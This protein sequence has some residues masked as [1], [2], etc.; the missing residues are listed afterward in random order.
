MSF[1]QQV[2]I[3]PA[4]AVEGDFASSNPRATVLAGGGA[5]VAGTGGLI[6]GRFAWVTLDSDGNPATALN[7][8]QGVPDG[9]VHREQQ[10]ILTQYLQEY[11]MLIP[12][13][14]MV[15]LH[16][17]GDFWMK[18]RT[19]ATRKQKAFASYIDGGLSTAAAGGSVAGFSGTASFATNVM[20]V[21]AVTSGTVNKGTKVTGAGVPANTYVTG[22]LTGTPGGAGT[23]SLST[24]PGTIGAEAITTSDYVETPWVVDSAGAVG[25]LVKIST[26]G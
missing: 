16:S 2:Q 25:E 11:G 8:G 4:R 14:F 23:Y 15:T 13:G 6:I 1:Q 10:G 5:L 3:V 17:Q 18:T 21:T 22:Q 26:W 9:F 24:T 7:S 12:A 19:V 20:T